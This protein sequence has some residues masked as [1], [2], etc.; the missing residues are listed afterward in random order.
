MTACYR[1]LG[2]PHSQWLAISSGETSDSGSFEA[3]ITEDITFYFQNTGSE[4]GYIDIRIGVKENVIGGY[5][6]LIFLI[7]LIS[8]VLFVSIKKKYSL[9]R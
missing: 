1:N 4:G 8:M 6:P 9:K 2:V 7:I 3:I 5:Y